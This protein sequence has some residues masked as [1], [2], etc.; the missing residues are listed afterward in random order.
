M[1]PNT[2][3]QSI[4]TDMIGSVDHEP[5]PAAAILP[6]AGAVRVA[7]T[8]KLPLPGSTPV[9]PGFYEQ[10]KQRLWRIQLGELDQH[11]A[12]S[13]LAGPA[14]LSDT[15][16]SATSGVADHYIITHYSLPKAL[17][18]VRSTSHSYAAGDDVSAGPAGARQRSR[19]AQQRQLGLGDAGSAEQF[20]YERE[21]KQVLAGP[22]GGKIGRHLAQ[23]ISN[24]Y[25]R[26]RYEP[27]RTAAASRDQQRAASR[28]GSRKP[29]DESTAG[30]APR[31]A[32]YNASEKHS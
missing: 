26:A 11:E 21:Q 2:E 1:S 4:R 20:N 9:A 15:E 19:D 30:A 5:G 27:L 17:V 6:P 8:A 31:Q 24:V 25:A 32:P 22:Q 10:Q 14:H 3:Q 7:A 16:R 12:N 28:D 13:L 29:L 18:G 23:K